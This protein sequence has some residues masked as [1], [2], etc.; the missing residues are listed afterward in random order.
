MPLIALHLR[1]HRKGNVWT[2]I[3]NYDASDER[4]NSVR[5][6][7]TLREALERAQEVEA[8]EHQRRYGKLRGLLP[9]ILS[10]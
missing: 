6:Y 1:R 7:P 8:E 5:P 9:R 10:P 2:L 4:A 3:E